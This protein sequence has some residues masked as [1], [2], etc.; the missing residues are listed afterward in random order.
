[1][2]QEELGLEEIK[3]SELPL[4]VK[5][6]DMQI[7]IRNAASKLSAQ[8]KIV[9][10]TSD[11]ARSILESNLRRVEQTMKKMCVDPSKVQASTA[12]IHA[13]CHV[14]KED[15]TNMGTIGDFVIARTGMMSSQMALNITGQNISNINTTGYTRRSLD[16]STFVV[17]GSGLY[18]SVSTV[19]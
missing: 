16:Q 1:K 12:G 19:Y 8:Y 14:Y 2:L 18:R 5:G 17:N 9:R 6:A 3:L 11:A 7:K 10:S 13:D 4:K 15:N